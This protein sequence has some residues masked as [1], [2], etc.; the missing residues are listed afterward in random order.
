MESSINKTDVDK[1]LKLFRQLEKLLNP[2]LP[3]KNPELWGQSLQEGKK[4]LAEQIKKCQSGFTLR[5]G[6]NIPPRKASES[7]QKKIQ[8]RFEMR[9]SEIAEQNYYGKDPTY[10]K[11]VN[12]AKS[13]VNNVLKRIDHLLIAIREPLLQFPR[14][15]DSLLAV[16]WK[17]HIRNYY[18]CLD[19]DNFSDQIR[20]AIDV[21]EALKLQFERQ[22]SKEVES[23][24]DAK[25][26]EK[27]QKAA[28]STIHIQNSNVIMG[29]V[30][31][32]GNLQVGDR[33]QIQEI[34]TGEEKNKGILKKVLK[35]GGTIIV[36]L[37]I[38]FLADIFANLGWTERITELIYRIFSSK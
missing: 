28:P 27:G 22:K 32:P 33:T 3:E 7:E 4:E 30:N 9:S 10:A 15:Q 29:D 5:P 21:L 37:F 19:K 8:Q 11:A 12:Q 17:K 14:V 1:L 6:G 20:E 36:G 26:A 31:Q 16:D 38:A 2:E 13:K 34:N 24:Q 18:P 25:P 35:I 23:Q